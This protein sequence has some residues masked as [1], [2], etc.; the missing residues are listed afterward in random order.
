[1]YLCA[2]ISKLKKDTN[3]T[4]E[5]SFEEGISETINWYKKHYKN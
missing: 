4:V 2:D 3:F 5:T 1:M